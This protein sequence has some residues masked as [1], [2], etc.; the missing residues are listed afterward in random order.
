MRRKLFLLSS[1]LLLLVGLN[2]ISSNKNDTNTIN[3]KPI[4]RV[5]VTNDYDTGV[6]NQ[7]QPEIDDDYIEEYYSSN[8]KKII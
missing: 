4:Q 5:N 8:F 1:I 3:L 7:I 2:N 6:F